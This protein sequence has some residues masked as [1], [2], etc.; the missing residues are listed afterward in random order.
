[1]MLLPF[2]SVIKQALFSFYQLNVPYS[3]MPRPLK[4][5]PALQPLSRQ[6]H[7]VLQ[8][9]FKVRKGIAS[10]VEAD[11]VLNYVRYFWNDFYTRHTRLQQDALQRV[12][13]PEAQRSFTAKEDQLVVLY[14]A[15]KPAN[16]NLRD[17][18]QAL[19]N[20]VRWE[21]RVLFEAI[22]EQF[23]PSALDQ[24]ITMEHDLKDWC[25]LYDDQ[26]WLSS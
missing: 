22:Q 15:L 2:G 24:L 18:E 3:I 12:L 8:C 10:K 19:Y 4:R 6:H 26:F 5:Y 16:E 21:E 13:T 1:M 25:E 11:R 14:H 7:K 17:F 20:Q 9:C 23:T